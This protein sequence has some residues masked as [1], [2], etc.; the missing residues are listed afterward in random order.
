MIIKKFVPCIYL[1][2]E[3]AVK[4]L[5]DTT[6]VDTNPVRL[7]KYYCENNA[8]ELIIFD[9]SQGDAEHETS[10]DIMKE[11]CAVAEVDVIGAGN[12]KRMEDVKKILYTGCKK[13][14]LNYDKETRK[15]YI[16]SK[17]IIPFNVGDFVWTRTPTDKE[18]SASRLKFS[19]KEKTGFDDRCKTFYELTFEKE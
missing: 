16:G 10:L 13:A 9:M 2:Q 7:A 6:I 8:D 19:S 18:S 17:Q 15:A 5:T 3:H 4:G 1:Y 12:I 14:I 11:I